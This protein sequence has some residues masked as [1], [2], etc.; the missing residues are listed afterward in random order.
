[1]LKTD[2]QLDT[3]LACDGQAP[4]HDM[5]CTTHDLHVHRVVKILLWQS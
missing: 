3:I 2:N 1:V 4:G 5:Y